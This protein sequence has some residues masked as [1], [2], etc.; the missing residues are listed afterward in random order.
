MSNQIR[1]LFCLAALIFSATVQG[2]DVTGSVQGQVIDA[3]GA[4]MP[5]V[6]VNLVN[7]GTRTILTRT[8]G[9][10]GEYSY[11][12]VPPGRYTVTASLTGFKAANVTGIDVGDGI[13]NLNAAV[14][15]RRIA[16]DPR[17]AVVP[18]QT[19]AASF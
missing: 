6:Q 11:N 5:D 7:E 9:S 8:T 17:P 4:R 13:V 10:E 15:H 16:T 12:L 19:A 3:S 1:S 2:Q 18:E 14:N